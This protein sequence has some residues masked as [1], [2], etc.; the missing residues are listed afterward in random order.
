MT[1][2][3]SAEYERGWQDAIDH[4]APPGTVE[5]AT[6]NAAATG[7]VRRFA[8]AMRIAR[9]MA[10]LDVEPDEARRVE[11]AAWGSVYLHGKWRFLTSQMTAEERSA[12]A[13]AVDRD[14]ARAEAEDPACTH[15]PDSRAELRWWES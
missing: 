12:A 7:L 2:P 8:D 10:A 11:D 13:D 14:W 15:G 9:A 1:E 5:R 4:L 6:L 3:N